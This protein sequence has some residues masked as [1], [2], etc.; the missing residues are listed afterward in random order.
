MKPKKTDSERAAEQAALRRRI[1][2]WLEGHRDSAAARLRL[3]AD[4]VEA[5]QAMLPGSSKAKAEPKRGHTPPK[6]E[7]FGSGGGAPPGK[8]GSANA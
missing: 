1:D 6:D 3:G 8:S 2:E 4:E 5:L 7:P